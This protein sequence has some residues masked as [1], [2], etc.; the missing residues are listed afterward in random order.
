MEQSLKKLGLVVTLNSGILLPRISDEITEAPSKRIIYNPL[1]ETPKYVHGNSELPEILPSQVAISLL[2]REAYPVTL[3]ED[4]DQQILTA[5]FAA[6]TMS[7]DIDK[8]YFLWWFNSSFEA[9]RQLEAS[10]QAGRRVV[11]K[12]LR[13]MTISLPPMST[14]QDV[15]AIYTAGLEQARLLEQKAVLSKEIAVQFISQKIMKEQ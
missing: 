14:Q 8:S 6:A 4:A 1:A 12:D 11:L 5:N 13:E 3:L 7:A 15:G 2:Q 10:G 9:R